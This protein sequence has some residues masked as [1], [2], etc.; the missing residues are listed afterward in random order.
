MVWT[1]GRC[2]RKAMHASYE[3][4]P[5]FFRPP[6]WLGVAVVKSIIIRKA[7][8]APAT[9][10]PRPQQGL[11]SRGILPIRRGAR[12]GSSPA[13]SVAAPKAHSGAESRRRL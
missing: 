4:G 11:S 3:A 2:S 1:P 6:P 9:G 7:H 12:V 8:Y 5:R 10:Y 13:A